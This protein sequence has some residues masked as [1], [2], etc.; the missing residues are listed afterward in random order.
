MENQAGITTFIILGCLA[1]F[2]LIIVIILFVVTY[3]RKM[4]LKEARI[5]LI[6]QEKQ[7]ELFKAT[8]EAEEQQK[9][10]IARNLHDEINPLLAVLK[11]NL[12]K[13]RIEIKKDKFEPESL[14]TDEKMLD[15]AIEGIRTTCLDLIP[16]FLLEY[17]LIKSLEGHIRNVQ[18]LEGMSAD[19]ENNTLQNELDVFNKQVQLNIYRV[20]LEIL[21]NQFKHSKCS[22]LK[23][24][25]ESIDS[26]LVITFAHNGI[27]VTNEEME[28][29]T[30]TSKGLGL[31]SLKARAL[32]LNAKIDYIKE[33]N[34]S[35]IKLSIPYKHD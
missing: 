8:V 13:H 10:K 21:N 29:H 16:S 35:L 25:T 22:I 1:M 7:I 34:M 2:C 31:K 26:A 33:I 18:Q 24:K 30:E 5:K 15:K 27:G 6:E 11:L 12:S 4:L 28:I 20:C 9:E 32:I 14:I 19:F 17:G 23:M 3:Q